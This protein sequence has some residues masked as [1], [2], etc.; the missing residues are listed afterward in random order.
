MSQMVAHDALIR[1]ENRMTE[2]L[3]NMI[4]VDENDNVEI[5][6]GIIAA[7]EPR[8]AAQSVVEVRT[9]WCDSL[10]EALQPVIEISRDSDGN[11]IVDVDSH[12]LGNAGIV[13]T[14]I[15]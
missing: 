14:Q 10:C 4:V 15:A 1:M 7:S 9:D 8:L 2:Y 13:L 3:Y 12:G 5:L 6:D 11:F